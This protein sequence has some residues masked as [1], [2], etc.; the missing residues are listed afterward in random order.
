M[1]AGKRGNKPCIRN[2]RITVHDVLSILASGMSNEDI[3]ADYPELEI[4]D[5]FS[6]VAIQQLITTEPKVT[7]IRTGN[8]ENHSILSV[9]LKN[10]IHTGN[11]FSPAR[12]LWTTVR[13]G[14]LSNV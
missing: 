7:W 14:Y 2:M 3:L 5:I 11:A 10:K 9:L 6:S 12:F 13:V 8:S 4:E 1:E